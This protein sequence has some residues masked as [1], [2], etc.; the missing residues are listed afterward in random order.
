MRRLN[1]IFL[2]FG[3]MGQA[4]YASLN[5]I[6]H[7]LR[8]EG[9]DP[10]LLA[11]LEADQTLLR[12]L[13]ARTGAK[14]VFVD[15]S[16]PKPLPL[17]RLLGCELGLGAGDEFLVY[18]ATPSS[19][20]RDNLVSICGAYPRALYFGE[21]PLFTDRAGLSALERFG[22]RVLCDF[23]DSESAAVRK[24]IAMVQGGFRIRRLGFWRL[25]SAGLHKLASPLHRAG[26]EGGALL[27]KGIHD[28]A[29]AAILMQQQAIPPA[30]WRVEAA[31]D[32]AFMPRPAES[33]VPDADGRTDA[34]GYA[35]IRWLASGGV[36]SEFHYSWIGVDRFDDL[37]IR[38]GHPS[39]R[40][41]LATCG[42]QE[43]AWLCRELSPRSSYSSYSPEAQEARIAIVDGDDLHGENGT[44]HRTRLI[45]NLL[46][47]PGIHP[48]V[49]DPVRREFLE[50]PE[51]GSTPLSRVLAFAVRSYVNRQP[52]SLAPLGAAVIHQAHQACFDIRDHARLNQG[53]G[54][55]PGDL[56]APVDQSQG[57][58]QA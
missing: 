13:P 28:F 19:W 42:L 32:L 52:L 27:D 51:T 41:L 29:L 50:L 46:T 11:V 30:G 5:E 14:P 45:I 58:V 1:I 9:I 44:A 25:N 40:Q 56:R 6:T 24:L 54:P 23:V 15:T 7:S 4:A 8:Q 49:F 53:L 37:S 43:N 20:H 16:A 31:A 35:R 38:L 47:R 2:G 12:E 21:K 36:D 57:I 34:A 3:R 18:D 26:V 17:D 33:L 22:S 55:E 48:F 39:L 10:S